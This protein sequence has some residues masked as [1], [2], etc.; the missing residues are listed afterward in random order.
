MTDKPTPEVRQLA[1][2]IKNNDLSGFR[3]EFMR[4]YAQHATTGDAKDFLAQLKQTNAA[5]L[6][7]DQNLPG[8]V[9]DDQGQTVAV[10]ISTPGKVFGNKWR[11]EE[12]LVTIVE[13]AEYTA[14]PGTFTI[15]DA[16]ANVTALEG[17]K[18]VAAKG[19][20]VTMDDWTG[21]LDA[22]SGSVVDAQGPGA[23]VEAYKG[24]IN[25]AMAYSNV[26]VDAIHGGPENY[27]SAPNTQEWFLQH[28]DY[29]T[30][31]DLSD[32]KV[33]EADKHRFNNIAESGSHVTVNNGRIVSEAGAR[34]HALSYS[35]LNAHDDSTVVAEAGA[36]LTKRNLTN[37]EGTS[38]V[39]IPEQDTI[40][41]TDP[42]HKIGI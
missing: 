21:V 29:R 11:N 30:V 14:K 4:E 10:G 41:D 34:T 16:G 3:D 20:N 31:R 17:A 9:I 33:A 6:K 18:F 22:K 2:K 23:I 27:H 1:D 12:N 19:S 5:D 37:R 25:T 42:R 28:P 36:H 39:S 35:F 24:S 7:A 40:V 15:A 26:E 8:L 13:S 32:P 38:V